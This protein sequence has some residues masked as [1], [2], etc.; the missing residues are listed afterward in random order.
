MNDGGRRSESGRDRLCSSASPPA[1]V[2]LGKKTCSSLMGL[3]GVIDGR[4]L[5]MGVYPSSPLLASSRAS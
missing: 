1:P 2:P 5:G 3:G 4:G